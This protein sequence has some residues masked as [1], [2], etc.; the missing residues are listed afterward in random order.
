MLIESVIITPAEEGRGVAVEVQGRLA[1]IIALAL[2][3]MPAEEPPLTA[4][5]ER[6]KG[7]G[8]YRNL[9]RAKA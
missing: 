9:T 8:R 2:G 6:V 7:S 5:V 1:N 4:K 3:N